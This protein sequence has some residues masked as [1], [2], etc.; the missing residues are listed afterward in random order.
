MR[1]LVLITVLW[2]FLSPLTAQVRGVQVPTEIV[3][4][5]ETEFAEAYNVNWRQERTRYV[6]QFRMRAYNM[7]AFFSVAGTWLFTDIKV[8][9]NDFPAKAK[10]YYQTQMSNV[11]ISRTGYH[12]TNGGGYYY[13]EGY[14]GGQK[15][16]FRFDDNG[17]FQGT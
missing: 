15:R 8:P 12:D 1:I 14:M 4:Q 17:L 16:R 3:Q 5:F 13:I 11:Q 9:F 10:S 7:E 2:G 6:A